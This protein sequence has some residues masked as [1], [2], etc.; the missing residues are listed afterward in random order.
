MRTAGEGRVGE[1]W[2]AIV[3]LALLAGMLVLLEVGF[4]IARRYT[5]AR[6]GEGASIF[7]TAVF[8]LLGLLL[9]FAFS[10]AVDRLDIRRS[11]IVDEANAIGTAYLRVDLLAPEH[12]PAMR[13][14][15]HDY[16]TARLDLYRKLDSGGDAGPH[17]ARIE[18]LQTQIW[19]GAVVGVS[20]PDDSHAAEVVLPAL[21]DMFD[22]TT[23]RKVA[24]GTHMPGL[25]LVLLVGVSLLSALI[26]GIGMA[27][28]ERR[29]V[30][31]G[32]IFALTV[33]LTVYTIL[34]LDDPRGGFIRMEAAESAL[35]TLKD[36]I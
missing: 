31:H 22:I 32:G 11:L 17:F 15:F 29:H 5:I 34:D 28:H 1:W 33:T 19:R 2:A 35:Q 27:A 18:D 26:A 7:D 16:L 12:Q 9:G 23:T 14:L 13:V 25:I 10:G 30:L 3:C 20:G 6:G 36:G 4:R 24:L 8:A 21:N